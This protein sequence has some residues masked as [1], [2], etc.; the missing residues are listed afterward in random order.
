MPVQTR[1][2]IKLA[3]Q[4]VD[5]LVDDYKR[6]IR[7]LIRNE[8]KIDK[9]IRSNRLELENFESIYRQMNIPRLCMA[10]G[11]LCCPKR[12]IYVSNDYIDSCPTFPYMAGQCRFCSRPMTRDELFYRFT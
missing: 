12:I 10:K 9:I 4:H 6:C 2:Q 11:T 1:S 8:K 7:T 5:K 3:D